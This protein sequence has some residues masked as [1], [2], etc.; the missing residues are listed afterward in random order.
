MYRLGAGVPLNYVEA[1][2]WFR[3]A[4][5]QGHAGSQV[6][7]GGKYFT[8]EGVPEDYAE[9]YAWYLLAKANG[10]E[11]AGGLISVLEEKFLTAKQMEKG[12]ARAAELQRSFGAK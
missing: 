4:A 6:E 7:L 10:S 8:G 3:K 1:E 12:Q 2:K 5:E 9:A 11:N